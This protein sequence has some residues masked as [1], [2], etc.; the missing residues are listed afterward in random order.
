MARS[1][2]PRERLGRIQALCT[3]ML[4]RIK[5]TAT[6][7]EELRAI[8][9]QRLANSENLLN[10][11][12][13]AIAGK[14]LTI[15]IPEGRSHEEIIKAFKDLLE[16]NFPEQGKH[17]LITPRKIAEKFGLSVE[18]LEKDITEKKDLKQWIAE[19]NKLRTHQGRASEEAAVVDDLNKLAAHRLC[20]RARV[21]RAQAIEKIKHPKSQSQVYSAQKLLDDPLKL[22]R[23]RL[24]EFWLQ[25][26]GG[27]TP[28]EPVDLSQPDFSLL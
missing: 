16:V 25:T 2:L 6:T 27:L 19:Q 17:G 10:P 23:H 4:D 9:N 3:P 5:A 21:T 22:I 12:N 14:R 20:K 18:E 1:T 24:K 13:P 15:I 28:I 7:D 8:E 11:W 26:I